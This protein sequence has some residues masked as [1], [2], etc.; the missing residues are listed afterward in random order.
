[1]LNERI[2]WIIHQVPRQ[3]RSPTIDCELN[4]HFTVSDDLTTNQRLGEPS[5]WG[6]SMCEIDAMMLRRWGPPIVSWCTW[7]VQQLTCVF[8]FSF[9]DTSTWTQCILSV[10][11]ASHWN[12]FYCPGNSISFRLR[13]H[14]WCTCLT[15]SFPQK[16]YTIMMYKWRHVDTVQHSESS[17]SSS[18][19]ECVLH[20]IKSTNWTITLLVGRRMCALNFSLSRLSRLHRA[21]GLVPQ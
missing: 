2:R 19:I 21:I 7:V 10:W 15:L 18:F 20:I 9:F 5:Q 6:I 1:M 3:M 17:S 11:M 12:R 8:F 16:L 4:K 14:K 13:L